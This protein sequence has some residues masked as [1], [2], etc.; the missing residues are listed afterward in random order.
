MFSDNDMLSKYW[1]SLMLKDWVSEV[2][3]QELV[4]SY[5]I[6]PGILRAKL[7]NADWLTY[8]SLELAKMLSLEAHF[9]PLN[10]MRKR[11][12]SGIKEELIPLC[13]LRGIGRVRAR[14][15]W[16]VGV[17][18]ISD[19]KRTDVKDLGKILGEKVAVKVKQQ[20]G[21]TK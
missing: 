16:G 4:D 1:T 21:A 13:E 2:R 14:R 20:L 12:Q 7:Q 17:K 3:E 15:L 19:V 18:G 8:S 6:Q 9:S 5:K 10:K 11:L